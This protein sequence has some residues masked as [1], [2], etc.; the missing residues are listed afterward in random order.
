MIEIIGPLKQG[1]VTPGGKPVPLQKQLIERLQQAILAGRLPAGASLPAS[2]LLPGGP[3][4]SRDTVV[5]AY[6]PL[7]GPGY[8]LA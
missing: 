6:E 4:G 2:R 8:L 5:V 3:R 1:A 7:L